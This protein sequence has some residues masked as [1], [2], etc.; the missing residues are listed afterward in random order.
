[1]FGT[2]RNYGPARPS[3]DSRC[4][5]F[6]CSADQPSIISLGWGSAQRRGLS[7]PPCVHA[8]HQRRGWRTASTHRLEHPVPS[9]PSVCM[10]FPTFIRSF[11]S[12]IHGRRRVFNDQLHFESA[13]IQS[14]STTPR[15]TSTTA[16]HRRCPSRERVGETG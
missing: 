16:T 5:D 3:A 6:R 13:A 12:G 15:S 7:A 4:P 1:M 2:S 14:S 9:L 11:V 10:G 8:T